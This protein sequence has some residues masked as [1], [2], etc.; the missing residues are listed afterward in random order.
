MAGKKVVRQ[1]I[2]WLIAAAIIFILFRTV[3]VNWAELQ[4]WNWQISWPLALLSILLLAAAYVTASQGWRTIL[5]GFGHRIRF[6]ESFRVVYLANLGRYIPGK[7][8]QVIG[9]V[10][11]AREVNIPA[12]ISLASFA[13]VQAYALP[14]SFLLVLIMLGYAAPLQALAVYRDIFYIFMAVVVLIFLILFFA[15]K[16]LN[17]A[18]NRILKLFRQEAVQYRPDFKNRL[19]I[20]AWYLVTWVFLGL[21][22]HFFVA[23]LIA[24]SGFRVLFSAGA[25]IAAYNLGYIS[26]ISPGGLG[27]REGVMSALLAPQLGGPVAASIALIHRVWITLAEAV[28]SLLALLTY[29]IKSGGRLPSK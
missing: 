16:G 4:N 17:W 9:M 27:V 20:F 15:P 5:Y 29:K 25:Y 8:W 19:A 18:L 11:L 28:I 23:A 21:S 1:I 13:L 12:K 22:F 26:F 3:Y 2:G 7:V 6:H 14:A 10:G 24:D